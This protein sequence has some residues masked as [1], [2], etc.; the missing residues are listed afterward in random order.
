MFL[1]DCDGKFATDLRTEP[2]PR[3]G[4]RVCQL[5]W[6]DQ[7]HSTG[8]RKNGFVEVH[9]RGETDPGWV[10]E[11]FTTDLGL[12][13]FYVI[14]VGQ[15]DGILIRT[16][17]DRW[18]LIDAGVA[19]ES[20]MTK[21]GAANFIRWKFNRDL[22]RPAVLATLT[23][24][25]P[26]YDHYGGILNLL[27]GDL[28]DDEP[29][30]DVSVERFYHSGMGRFDTGNPLGATRRGKV[31]NFP[32]GGY[33]MSRTDSFIVELLDDTASFSTPSSPFKGFFADLAALVAT[34]IGAAQRI[35]IVGNEDAWLPGYAPSDNVLSSD[36]TPLAIKLLGPV[37]EKFTDNGGATHVGLRQLESES[38]TRNGHS[39]TM[40]FDYGNARIL[41]NGDL[42]AESQRLLLSYVDASEYSCDVAKGCHHGSEDIDV[43]FIQAMQ[44]RAT[45]I[46]SG[47]N[48]DYAHPRPVVVGASAFYGR[49]IVTT[50]DKT[51]PPLVYSTELARS[52]KL[53]YVERVSVD[54]D[55][56]RSARRA[57]FPADR[58]RV[59]PEGERYREFSRTPIATNLVYGLVNIRTDGNRI[60][61]ATME[62]KGKE[63]DIKTF[64]AG[65]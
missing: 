54:H 46:S 64:W 48:E 25:H 15:G 33:Q 38:K 52:T 42:N 43:R 20:Q 65:R 27:S 60:M 57:S 49:E 50:D 2:G 35:G 31:A 12:L 40:R 4:D 23:M 53:K 22:K 39:V 44:S 32:V 37:F 10:R 14:D 17:D 19:N 16:P 5:I 61:C 18:H 55:N 26:D 58:S 47:D 7:L 3:A 62:E 6:G 9:A 29:P 51:L 21:K 41:M 24:S 1:N 34:R 13:E 28:A 11:G 56:D 63:F 45:V 30:F 36:G 59:K 8:N